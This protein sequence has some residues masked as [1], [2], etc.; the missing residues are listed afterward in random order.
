MS[1]NHPL[2]RQRDNSKYMLANPNA[3]ES[4]I[5]SSDMREDEFIDEAE[6]NPA[7]V[8]NTNDAEY[9]EEL[10]PRMRS[11]SF[12]RNRKKQ[13]KGQHY[14]SVTHTNR[15][16]INRNINKKM[17]QSYQQPQQQ[18]YY[19]QSEANE[20]IEYYDENEDFNEDYDEENNSVQQPLNRLNVQ[21]AKQ[22]TSKVIRF[23]K[24][25]L[26]ALKIYNK[27]NDNI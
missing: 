10:S 16:Q 17:Q 23:F 5:Y 1:E 26:R 27:S 8:L 22:L 14:Q 2:D 4:I 3:G 19:Y 15:G 18:G 13:S 25:L 20:D 9:E 24:I 11:N 6:T 21:S 7:S 12:D